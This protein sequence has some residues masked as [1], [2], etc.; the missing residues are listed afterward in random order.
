MS[1]FSAPGVSLPF[2]GKDYRTRLRLAALSRISFTHLY[3]ARDV[4]VA[5]DAEAQLGFRPELAGVTE[6]EGV[7]AQGKAISI[8]WDWAALDDGA[9][10]FVERVPPR[11]NVQVIDPL[12]YDIPAADSAQQLKHLI[13]Q[14]PWQRPVLEAL[15]ESV[16]M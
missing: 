9:V 11:T 2:C 12:G 3:T 10:C 13:A 5:D 7:D 8:G 14:L 16:N 6:W 1:A 15:A 4:A